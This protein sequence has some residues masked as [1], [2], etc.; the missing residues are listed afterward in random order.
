MK[1]RLILLAS[2]FLIATGF[3]TLDWLFNTPI[4]AWQTLEIV[5]S[6]KVVAWVCYIYGVVALALGVFLLGLR[7]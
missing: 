6:V 5:P 3:N 7:A 2:V 1:R 4:K